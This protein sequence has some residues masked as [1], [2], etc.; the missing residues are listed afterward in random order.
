MSEQHHR[1][2]TRLCAAHA[3]WSTHC[4][5]PQRLLFP[6]SGDY[7]N[8]VAIDWQCQLLHAHLLACQQQHTKQQQPRRASYK[9][10]CLASGVR[11]LALCVLLV[12]Q[13]WLRGRHGATT[14]EPCDYATHR[15]YQSG[16]GGFPPRPACWP[17]CLHVRSRKGRHQTRA[18]LL[19][20]YMYELQRLRRVRIAQV[21]SFAPV[22]APAP[23]PAPAPVSSSSPSPPPSLSSLAVASRRDSG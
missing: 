14:V 5:L 18:A 4:A 2:I 12:L 20:G 1:S 21:S 23:A 6:R 15:T 22:P 13:D 11:G 17:R 8:H 3:G 19:P 10:A 7:A 9:H 16:G